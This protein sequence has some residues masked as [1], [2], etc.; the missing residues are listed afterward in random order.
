[1]EMVIDLCGG[2]GAWSRPY[3]DAGYEV[4]LVTLPLNDVR[5]FVGMPGVRG[6]LCAPPLYRLL[7]GRGV[8]VADAS[9]GGSRRGDRRRARLPARRKGVLAEVVGLGEPGGTDQDV[10]A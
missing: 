4:V 8:D 6:V 5:D 10:R 7:E 1:M 9:A 3:K 2:R